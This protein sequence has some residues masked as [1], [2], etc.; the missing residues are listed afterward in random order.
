MKSTMKRIFEPFFTTKE[1]GKG[2]GLGLA[3]AYGI[4]KQHKGYIT[5]SSLLSQGTTFDV[6]LPLVKTP[7]REK[8][9]AKGDMKGGTETILI[10]ED[11]RDVRN[12][13]TDILKSQGY[14]TLEAIDGD[15]AVRVHHEHK[16]DID[17]II[18]DVVMPRKNGKEAFDEITRADPESRRSS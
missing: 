11:D 3:S 2:T 18:L 13:L 14:T 4:V 5:V 7:P 17:L 8:A 15:D 9:P 6:Y 12:M 10:V 1:V 16:D